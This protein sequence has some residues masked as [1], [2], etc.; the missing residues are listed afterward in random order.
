[1]FHIQHASKKLFIVEIS[2]KFINCWQDYAI[3][4]NEEN[5]HSDF[6]K[7]F[8]GNDKNVAREWTLERGYFNNNSSFP[9]R[10]KRSTLKS[11]NIKLNQGDAENFCFDKFFKI[12]PHLPNE[13]PTEFHNTRFNLNYMEGID[14]EVQ[15]KSIRADESLRKVPIEKRNCYFEDERKLLFFHSYT[16]Q[17]CSLECL[18]NFIE[19]ECGC[20]KFY[21]PRKKTTKVCPFSKIDCFIKNEKKFY[22]EN[23]LL[24]CRCLSPCNQIKY[25]YEVYRSKMD[26]FAA[27]ILKEEA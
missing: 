8:K 18:A 25:S 13:I 24:S 22:S 14:I 16:R 3:I 10:A 6:E 7:Y 23:E 21:M 20:V 1:M 4:F 27:I 2:I 9:R 11:L 15:A 26:A 5:T 17:H 12:I 19:K